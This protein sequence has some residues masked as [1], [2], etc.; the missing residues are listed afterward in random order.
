VLFLRLNYLR[1][2]QGREIKVVRK[3]EIAREMGSEICRET[4]IA[5]KRWRYRDKEMCRSRYSFLG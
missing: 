2:F 3:I 4:E 1:S 5:E